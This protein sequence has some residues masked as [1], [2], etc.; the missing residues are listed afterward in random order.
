MKQNKNDPIENACAHTDTDSNNYT[1]ASQPTTKKLIH[2]K[3]QNA[4]S[5]SLA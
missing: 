5:E 4:G 1:P 2:D 3:A